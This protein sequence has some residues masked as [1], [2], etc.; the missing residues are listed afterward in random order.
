VYEDLTPSRIL[1]GEAFEN[2]IVVN[3]AI[4]GSTNAP[5]HLQAIARHAGVPLA[6]EDW[7]HI[8]FE[9]PLLANIQPA[10]EF[11]GEAFFRAGGVPA[12]MGELQA[13]GLLRRDAVTI[14]GKSVAD[15]LGDARSRDQTVI[16]N[17]ANPIRDNAGFVV[18]SGNLFDSALM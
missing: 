12:I 11:L 7:Q 10:G 8:G 5:P 3:S 16:S 18:L 17:V 13:A 9:I 14:T 4:G 15:N 2:A 1:T 6:V